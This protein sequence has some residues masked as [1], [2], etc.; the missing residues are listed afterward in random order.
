MNTVSALI[1]IDTL[2]ALASGSA[3]DNAYLVDTNGF[4]GSWHEGTDSLHTV[5]QDGQVV[6]W[7]VAAVSPDGDV[8]ITGLS[9]DMVT[10]GI[11]MP[12]ASGPGGDQYWSGRVEAQGQ[13]ASFA[14]TATLSIGGS[15]MSLRSYL[16]V[17]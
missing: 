6:K 10:G 11:C 2:G 8:T 12:I 15:S 17:A 9:G 13:F 7:S 4:L 5:C 1:V 14:Y 16:K 3:I